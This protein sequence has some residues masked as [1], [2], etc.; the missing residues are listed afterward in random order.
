MPDVKVR[1]VNFLSPVGTGLVDITHTDFGGATPKAVLI[2]GGRAGAS[3]TV[4]SDSIS[5]MIGMAVNGGNQGSNGCEIADN[6]TTSNT[7][8]AWRSDAVV[9][10]QSQLAS[11][12][13]W[14]AN[15][16]RINFTTNAIGARQFTAILFGGADVTAHMGNLA[17]ATGVNQTQAVT[18]PGF[19]PD[20]VFV[21]TVN[22]SNA[23]G[24][25]TTQAIQTYGVCD[26]AGAK[27]FSVQFGEL[28]ANTAASSPTTAYYNN[29]VLVTLNLSNTTPGWSALLNNFG[30]TGFDVVY[31]GTTAGQFI[32]Y[33]ALKFN[34]IP[35]DLRELTVPTSTGNLTVTGVGFTPQALFFGG[36][37][38]TVANAVVINAANSCSFSRSAADVN[39]TMGAYVCVD[40]FAVDPS[41]VSELNPTNQAYLIGNATDADASRGALTSMNAGTGYT[42][43]FDQVTGAATLFWALAIGG[44]DAVAS[45]DLGT[46]TMTAPT[47]AGFLDM[48]AAGDVGTVTMS[49]P[50]GVAA[51]V[52][53]GRMTQ[54]GLELL[55]KV[56]SNARITQV[57]I[58]ALLRT[59]AELRVTQMGILMLARGAAGL[60]VPDQLGL[61]DGGRSMVIRQ[62]LVNMYSEPTPQGPSGS[63][64]IGRPGLYAATERGDGPIRAIFRWKKST[65]VVVSGDTV[66]INDFPVGTI[67]NPD[68]LP[69]RWAV[70]DDECVI[71][72]NNRAYY[73]TIYDVTIIENENLLNVIDVKFMAGRFVYTLGDRSG[74]Y[75]YSDAGDAL[76]VS[77][78][79]FISAEANPDAITSNATLGDALVF[80]GE[81]T[82]EFHYATSD[83]AAP[84]QRSGGRRYDKGCKSP[85]S[86]VLCDNTL[87]FLGA[88]KKLYRTDS[89]P[90]L[91]SNDDFADRA[92]RVLDA[93]L[94]LVTAFTVNVGNHEF[95]VINLPEQGSWA[96]DFA[97]KTWAEWKSWNKPRFR[98]NCADENVLGDIYSGVL[99]GM[100]GQRFKD[101]DDPLERVCS[102]FQPLRS[103]MARNFNLALMAKRGVGLPTGQGSIPVVDMRFSDNQDGDWSQWIP[104][105]LGV[106][107]DRS[108]AAMALWTSLGSII[109]PGRQF[110]FRCSDPVEFLPYEVKINEV[111]P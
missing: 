68:N 70:S 8:R 43:N 27:N 31:T 25:G 99:A 96:Y 63:M 89:V 11:V 111:R 26:R 105:P 106:S 57:G 67:P 6:V 2:F 33:L 34:G 45:G 76:T 9:R 46:V 53:T 17:A 39:L 61:M 101:F 97:Q 51:L 7:S 16:V 69:V 102:T 5:T 60:I 55:A 58:S 32:Q 85:H 74:Q 1:V 18:A 90:I 66:Y 24:S 62:R 28:N 82:V 49:A 77:G 83:P 75:F 59:T 22:T 103:G 86:V 20:V 23:S 52:Q 79:S 78:T 42:L 56:E 110:E 64:R 108:R 19:Q 94:G 50:T 21:S 80:F 35:V 12:N 71:I 14:I 88:D 41:N 36:T 40:D 91:V 81:R 44:N 13:S 30:A 29:A 65:R 54:T 107:G 10:N 100:D 37:M 84:F 48:V 93:D 87:I 4:Q 73:V 72:S 38:Q 92:R 109:P 95:Y 47:G 15:G 3:N 98:V 104:A